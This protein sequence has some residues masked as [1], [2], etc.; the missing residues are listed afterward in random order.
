MDKRKR[1]M[2]LI[3]FGKKA[4]CDICQSNAFCDDCEN[5]RIADHLLSNDVTIKTHGEWEI[6]DCDMFPV[7]NCSVCHTASVAGRTAY[8]PCCGAQM[9]GK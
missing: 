1:L 7:Y 5:Q 4:E 6:G 3:E 9:K 2:E 8:C